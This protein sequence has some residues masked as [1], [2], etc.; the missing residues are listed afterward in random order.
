M[1]VETDAQLVRKSLRHPESFELVFDR[2]YDVVRVYAQRRAGLS[3]GEE[4]AS[5]TF[6]QAFAQR[7][8]F[9]ADRFS[10]ARPWLMGIANNLIR[11]HFRHEDVRRRHWPVSIALSQVEAEPNLDAL[12]AHEQAPALLEAL[13]GLPPIDRETFL[14]VVVGELTY[15]ETAEVLR[16]PQGTV[17]SRVNRVRST[18]RE[19]LQSAGAIN[20]GDVIEGVDGE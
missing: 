13:R 9:D 19:L 5:E 3:D 6:V 7:D 10:S 8:R 11:R 4:I 17:R 1:A 2:H 18:L 20:P 12:A 16:I 15:A 14:I